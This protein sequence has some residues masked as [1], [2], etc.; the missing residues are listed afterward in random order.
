MAKA[1]SVPELYYLTPQEAPTDDDSL[2]V[3]VDVKN[4]QKSCD[5][6]N[7]PSKRYTP[8]KRDG[9]AKKFATW[10]VTTRNVFVFGVATCTVLFVLTTA[11]GLLAGFIIYRTVFEDGLN[12][13]RLERFNKE[14][15][16][17][18]FAPCA[19]SPGWFQHGRSCFLLD[20][21]KLNFADASMFCHSKNAS[22]VCP[23][24][25]PENDFLKSALQ[26]YGQ[27][28]RVWLGVRLNVLTD[29]WRC[30]DD[31]SELVY[32]DWGGN[33]P[34]GKEKYLNETCAIFYDSLSFR[35]GDWECHTQFYSLC[36]KECTSSCKMRPTDVT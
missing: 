17:D 12:N 18:G 6:V 7:D 21:N 22:M 10:N 1:K 4:E 24:L 31:E 26:E 8:N 23:K 14:C 30:F 5:G 32:E 15:Y 34:N 3:Y 19:C 35:W 25:K 20:R 36:R 9:S 2:H 28:G 11:A 33:E 13:L 16:I 29:T 27:E